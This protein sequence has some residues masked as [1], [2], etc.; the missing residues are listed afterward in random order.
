MIR[1]ANP[2]KDALG[3][4]APGNKMS[5]HAAAKGHQRAAGFLDECYEAMARY[6][7]E[8]TGKHGLPAYLDD[9]I[10]N[11]PARFFSEVVKLQPKNVAIQSETRRLVVQMIEDNRS[12]PALQI[13]PVD[14]TVKTLPDTVP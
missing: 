6:V 2:D 9:L 10:R 7:S 14:A 5:Q 4:F 8:R 1:A 13:A 12:E 3:R 11:D